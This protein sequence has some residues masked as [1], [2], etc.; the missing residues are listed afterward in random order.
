[1]DFAAGAIHCERLN[2]L[3]FNSRPVTLKLLDT[4]VEVLSGDHT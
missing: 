2:P 3:R 4:D 1:M